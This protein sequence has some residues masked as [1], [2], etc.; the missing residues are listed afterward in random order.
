MI[1]EC[2]EWGLLHKHSSL[3]IAWWHTKFDVLAL[4]EIFAIVEGKKIYV[5]DHV[6]ME[7]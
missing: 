7:M 2:Y 6:L 5:I 3:C 4:L 1:T